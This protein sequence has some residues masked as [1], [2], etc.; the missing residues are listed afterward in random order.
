MPPAKKKCVAAL[1]VTVRRSARTAS[2]FPAGK[3]VLAPRQAALIQTNYMG[4]APKMPPPKKMRDSFSCHSAP[5]GKNGFRF[6]CRENCFGTALSR[7][8]SQKLYGPGAN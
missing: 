2:G 3:T 5:L 8:N 6:S 7:V 4:Q 1:A